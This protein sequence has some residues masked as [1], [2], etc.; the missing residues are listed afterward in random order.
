MVPVAISGLPTTTSSSMAGQLIA[1]VRAG[2]R[3]S[4]VPLFVAAPR[5][6]KDKRGAA[7]AIVLAA[8]SRGDR[9]NLGLVLSDVAKSG[10]QASL[11]PVLGEAAIV[12]AEQGKTSQL[13]AAQKD[14]LVIAN[15]QGTIRPVALGMAGAIKQGGSA[16]LETAG[17]AISQAIAGGPDSQ[18]ALARATANVFCEGGALAT[19]W[20]AAFSVAL[21]QDARGCLVLNQARALAVTTCGGGE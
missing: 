12:A 3:S 2:R 19:A 9:S 10:Q 7:N 6:A 17:Q 1:A 16:G 20:A 5:S 15:Q 4:A 8:G 21:S 13:A 14:A 18:Q 11:G